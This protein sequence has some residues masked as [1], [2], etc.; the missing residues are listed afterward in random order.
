MKNRAEIKVTREC[1]ES[2]DIPEEHLFR[3]LAVKIISSMPMDELQKIISFKKI[4]PFSRE[5]DKEL[6]YSDSYQS[7]EMSKIIYMMRQEDVVL[8]Q[9]SCNLK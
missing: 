4:D 6:V 5:I 2:G 8:F 1:L 3:E 7:D 9:A